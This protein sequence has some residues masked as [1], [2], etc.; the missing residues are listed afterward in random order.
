M[1]YVLFEDIRPEDP[2]LFQITDHSYVV[3]CGT[4]VSLDSGIFYAAD[5]CLK[6][7]FMKMDT[8][9]PSFLLGS[10]YVTSI[11]VYKQAF[12]RVCDIRLY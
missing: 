6:L 10:I 7:S 9:S 11:V 1:L 12:G 4:R 2:Q 8:T 5:G 3:L